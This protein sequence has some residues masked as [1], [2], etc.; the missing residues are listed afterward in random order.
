MYLEEYITV[1]QLIYLDFDGSELNVP[2]NDIGYG[3]IDN[4][5]EDCS[6]TAFEFLNIRMLFETNAHSLKMTERMMKL[7]FF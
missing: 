2:T 1:T 5:V 7:E 6:E 4:Y 3:S